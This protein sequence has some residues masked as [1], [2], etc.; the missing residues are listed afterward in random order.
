MIGTL[1]SIW[2]MASSSAHLPILPA[3]MLAINCNE[4]EMFAYE[5]NIRYATFDLNVV[6]FC[7]PKQDKRP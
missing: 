3:R 4:C 6:A 2:F 1:C 7:L 5:Y